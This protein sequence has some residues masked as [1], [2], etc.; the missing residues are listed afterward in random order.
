MA[1]KGYFPDLSSDLNF[2]RDVSIGPGQITAT[3]HDLTPNGKVVGETPNK[4]VFFSGKS[5]LVKYYSIWPDWTP[6]DV[7]HFS[8][9]CSFFHR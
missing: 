2:C 4:W 9:G 6:I 8:A 3:S 7:L 1:L 5:G